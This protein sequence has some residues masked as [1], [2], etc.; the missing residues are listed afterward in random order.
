MSENKNFE[1]RIEW[2]DPLVLWSYNNRF[3]KDHYFL[4][5]SLRTSYSGQ[6][7]FLAVH[8]KQSHT[9]LSWNKL[10]GL[11]SSNQDDSLLEAWFVTIPY[12]SYNEDNIYAN[13][14]NCV[15]KWDHEA[16]TLTVHYSDPSYLLR[17]KP[18]SLESGSKV[19]TSEINNISSNMTKDL[20]L[21]NVKSALEEIKNGTFYQV[22]V[23][24]KFRVELTSNDY[25][26]SSL[27]KTLCQRSPA[28]YSAFIQLQNQTVISS[29]PE[30]FLNLNQQKWTARPIKGTQ[31]RDTFIAK[32]EGEKQ[33]KNSL[34]DQSE[35]LM[36]VDLMRNDLAQF[37][38][39]GSIKVP[40]LFDIDSFETVHHMSSTIEGLHNSTQSVVDGIRQSFPPG[41]MTG[42]PKRKAIEYANQYEKDPRGIYSGAIGYICPSQCQL[43]VVI[44]TMIY[45]NNTIEFQVGGA[46]VNGSD[47]E[48]EWYET[49]VKAA[50]ICNSL[51][52]NAFTELAK[53]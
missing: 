51:G 36:I 46:I 29:S 42:T 31:K 19:F 15:Y 47:P 48:Q 30:L 37:C 8:P 40:E 39:P 5:S 50:G 16:L 33:L 11:V 7:S 32:K 13:Q 2:I 21:N 23:T 25:C 41:S 24:R 9:N 3:I 26:I 22:N 20:Y 43:S 52:I 4:Y 10:E 53:L 28:P 6:F 14:F 38:S 27:F 44:R 12:E 49:L 17:H 34:K 1:Q 45:K 35:N 18:I